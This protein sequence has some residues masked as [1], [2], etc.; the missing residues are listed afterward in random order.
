MTVIDRQLDSVAR[1]ALDR[2]VDLL[3]NAV[4][5]TLGP[6]GRRDTLEPMLHG[7]LSVDG[8]ATFDVEMELGDPLENHGATMVKQVVRQTFATCSATFSSHSRSI[9]DSSASESSSSACFSATS[10]T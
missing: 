1:A 2:G 8:D 5:A 9:L 3:A 7:H 6:L 10:A 4:K